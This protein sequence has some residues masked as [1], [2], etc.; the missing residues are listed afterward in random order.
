M[1]DRIEN[2]VEGEEENFADLLESFDTQ[3]G[4]DVSVGDKIRGEIIAIGQDAVFVNTGTKSDGIVEKDELL[5]ENG[6]FPHKVGDLLDLYVISNNGQEIKLSRALSG[7]GG[8]DLLTDAYEN[9]IPV[10][11]RVKAPCKGGFQVEILKRR[12]F[13]PISQMDL[14]YIEAPD[15]YVGETYQFIIMQLE[16]DA[17]NIVLSRRKLLEREQKKI[18]DVFL[19]E[20][21]EGNVLEGRVTKLMPYGAFVEL[22]PGIEG[23]VHISELSWSR[24]EKASEVLSPLDLVTVKVIGI[25]KGEKTRIPKI[26]LSVKQVTEDPWETVEAQFQSGQEVKGTV[27]RCVKFGAFVEIAPGIE[28]LVHISEMSYR[29]RVSK[30][31]EVVKTG[32]VVGVMIKDIDPAARR[33]SLSMKDV[34]GDPWLDVGERYRV[35]QTVQGRI[36]KREA[37]GIFIS[38]E[39]GITGLLP[40]SNLDR[41]PDGRHIA[42]LR[43]G[44]AI[45]VAIHAVDAEARKITLAPGDAGE[46]THWESFTDQGKAMGSLGSKL[47]KAFDAKKA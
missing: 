2:G 4:A 44:N 46:E 27:K 42:Q 39:P 25:E 6:Q 45:P 20:L 15:D 41:S 16:E 5:D 34:E 21:R 8:L 19:E 38:L 26:A 9:A 30:P 29:K 23:M 33:I 11:G 13:C 22:I 7:V 37:F 1:T 47:K 10:E 18:H 31:E 14:R 28:G 32:D 36:E 40:K 12:A 35:G 24:V 17:R 43:E 3:A